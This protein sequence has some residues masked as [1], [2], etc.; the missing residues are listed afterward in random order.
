M[1]RAEKRAAAKKGGKLREHDLPPAAAAELLRLQDIH[2]KATIVQQKAAT[3]YQ[4]AGVNI[5]RGMNIGEPRK[6]H[7]WVVD[8]QR[9]KVVELPQPKRRQ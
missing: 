1:G 8:P 4:M 7:Q 6:G 3:D 9:K 5:V 2:E